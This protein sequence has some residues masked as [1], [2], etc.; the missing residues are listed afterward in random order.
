MT[1]DGAKRA[2]WQ[3]NAG[4]PFVKNSTSVPG[5]GDAGNEELADVFD[6]LDCD[7]S[8]KD[9]L[10][11]E[12][13]TTEQVEI[14]ADALIR[15]LSSLVDG[16]VTKSLW[17]KMEEGLLT[18]EKSRQQQF[19]DDE[20]M[21]ILELMASAPNHNATFLLLLSFLQN[22]TGQITDSAKPKAVTPRTSVDLP[23]SPTVKVRRRALSKVPEVAVRQ[24]IVRNYAVTFA[25]VI[26]RASDDAKMRE[27]DKAVRKERMV[28]VLELFLSSEAH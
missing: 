9:A 8:I 1:S 17:E 18:R 24:L 7:M 13:Q 19:E 5:E 26:F 27:R 20:K 15:F 23:S 21:W 25:D 12:T 6:A 22:L 10:R 16:V 28:R 11:P 4:W 14:V 2:P 3:D